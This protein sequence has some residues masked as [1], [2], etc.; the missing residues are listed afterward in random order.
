MKLSYKA[1]ANIAVVTNSPAS[2]D[3]IFVTED[4]FIGQPCITCKL[5]IQKFVS[6]SW[7]C[8]CDQGHW[9][10]RH[11]PCH[12][13]ERLSACLQNAV[14]PHLLWRAPYSISLFLKFFSIHITSFQH[15][16][17][18]SKPAVVQIYSWSLIHSN[19]FLSGNSGAARQLKTSGDPKA[20]YAKKRV[21]VGD[22]NLLTNSY[23]VWMCI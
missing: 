18:M 11:W 20:W 13:G 5:W 7:T 6:T 19:I 2:N 21:G 17:C 10:T 15:Q 12:A 3:F 14:H 16:K 23:S 22:A 1:C 9:K 4:R 8:Q